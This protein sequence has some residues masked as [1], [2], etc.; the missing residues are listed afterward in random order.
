[1]P[2]GGLRASVRHLNNY[3]YLLNNKGILKTGYRILS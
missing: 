1:M 3:M 2:H